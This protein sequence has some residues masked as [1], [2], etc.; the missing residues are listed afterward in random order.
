MDHI[1]RC[2]DRLRMDFHME[3]KAGLQGKDSGYWCT[4]GYHIRGFAKHWVQE[5]YPNGQH[6]NAP[7]KTNL[8]IHGHFRNSGISNYRSG[9]GNGLIFL[10]ALSDHQYG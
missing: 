2:A 10:C 7:H 6:H 8:Q 3:H 1:Q 9:A 5:W 4:G